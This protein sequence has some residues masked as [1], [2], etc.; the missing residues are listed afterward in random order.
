[1]SPKILIIGGVAGGMSAA[2]RARRINEH[3]QITVLE[4]GGFVSF[5]NCGMP[6]YIA[7][8]I[9]TEDK[10]LVTTPAALKKRFNIDARVGHEATRIDRSARKVQ[11]KELATGK[12]YEL[13]YDKLILAPGAT[14][15]IPPIEHVRSPNVFLLRTMEDTQRVQQW[16]TQNKPRSAAIIGAGFIGLEMAEA[17]RDRGISVS[18]VEK[19]DHVLP[20]LDKEMATWVAD[21]L[22]AHEVSL[23][24]GVGLKALRARDGLVNQ[25]ELEDG[26]IIDAD[27]VMMSI[28][29]RPNIALAQEAGLKLGASGAIAVD[30]FMRTS[31]LDVYAVG[32][33]AEVIHGVTGQATRIPLAGPANRNGRLAGEHAASGSAPAAA[34]VLGTAVVRVFGVDAAITGLGED[35]ARK[36]GFDV[37]T[38]Y[39]L[40]NHHAGYY[41]GAK[42]LRIKL[43][44]EKPTGRILGGQVVGAEGVDKRADV[45]ATTIHFKGTIDDLAGLD[46]CYAPQFGSAKDPVHMAAMV[47]QN[48]RR[49]LHHAVGAASINGE[50]LIDVRTPT[51]FANG[52]L[53]GAVNIPV[54]DL[55]GKLGTLDKNAPI[56]VFCQVGLRGYVA[57]RILVQNGFTQV[58]NIKGGYT[59]A[60]RQGAKTVKP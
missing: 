24:I 48:Q 32:D 41:P 15:I 28:G 1:M 57:Q 33:A 21:E 12:V 22:K 49:Q 4:K 25:V 11:V 6:Y 55:R 39:A 59:F 46:L 2:T 23:Y 52:T 35:Q 3:A 58:R 29:V 34:P 7:G 10:L 16:L 5:A 47:A 51:E 44:Y 40:P 31:D 14:P 53:A 9:Q 50:M 60:S 17:L 30:P 37:E 38:A 43:I 36:A 54:D 26:R 27:V 42:Q 19:V 18:L 56:T 20:P 8:R 45:I 13:A